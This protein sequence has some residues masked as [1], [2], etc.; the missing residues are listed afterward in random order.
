MPAAVDQPEESAEEPGEKTT[1]R[2]E[3]VEFPTGMAITATHAPAEP[4][5]FCQHNDVDGC[6]GEQ[7]EHRDQRAHHA[8]NL[9]QSREALL[10][11]A[12]RQGN[13]YGCDK[14]HR[15]MAKGE[16]KTDRDRPLAFL[17]QFAGNV[18]DCRYVIGIHR[19][20]QAEAVCDEAG[21]EQQWIVA[22][23][24]EG[25]KPGKQICNAEDG[26]ETDH[27]RAYAIISI[28]EH[29]ENRR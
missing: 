19:V 10:E 2:K 27:L 8:A 21:R 7:E 5:D 16:V 15:G 14:H 23:Q 9:D 17:H 18:V 3:N 22:E 12:R 26:V 13:H 25:P 4:V 6:D 1:L 11:A 28:V 24:D 20:P 29:R